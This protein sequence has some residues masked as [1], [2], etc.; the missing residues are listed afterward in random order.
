MKKLSILVF[1][2]L[3]LLPFNIYA[4]S[5]SDATKEIDVSKKASL[6]IKYK[7]DDI[8]I[9]DISVRIY[10]VASVSKDFQYTLTDSFKSYNVKINGL[11]TQNELNSLSDTLE[12]Y[13]YADLI[14]ETSNGVIKNNKIQFNELETGLYLVI[15]DK[16]DEEKYNLVFESFL[17]SL[18]TLDENNE[19][20]YNTS[21]EPK[22]VFYEPKYEEITYSV[23]KEWRDK[24]GKDR[25][26]SVNIEIYKDGNKFDVVTLSS[27]NNWCYSW[28]ALDDGSV[29]TVVEREIPTDYTVSIT[30]NETKFIVVNTKKE[31]N[32]PTLDNI[33]LYLIL[34]TCSFVGIVSLLLVLKN[35]EYNN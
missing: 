9:N 30:K 27:N 24:E 11:K 3:L 17:I 28:N 23:I 5:T 1:T 34:F 22:P 20:I 12:S 8:A 21:S 7:Y 10:K 18:P 13:I 15:T 31:D 35:S 32:P 2:L 4:K 33:Y 19:W 14:K 25:P 16:I 26:N 6:E 29:Y